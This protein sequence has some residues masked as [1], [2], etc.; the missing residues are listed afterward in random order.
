MKTQI[1]LQSVILLLF[2]S[3]SHVNGQTSSTVNSEMNT[4]IPLIHTSQRWTM[5]AI[6]NLRGPAER[7]QSWNSVYF[8]QLIKLSDVS[9]SINTQMGLVVEHK[10]IKYENGYNTLWEFKTSDKEAFLFTDKVTADSI[11]NGRPVI[12]LFYLFSGLKSVFYEYD[13]HGN[14]IRDIVSSVDTVTHET[15]KVYMYDRSY[16]DSL[17]T[18]FTSR[19]WDT[20]SNNWKTVFD[21]QESIEYNTNNQPVVSISYYNQDSV[22]G[23]PTGGNKSTY[24]YSDNFCL[25]RN[26]YYR[27]DTLSNWTLSSSDTFVNDENCYRISFTSNLGDSLVKNDYVNS[28]SSGNVLECSKSVFDTLTSSFIEIE[29]TNCEYNQYGDPI[30]IISRSPEGE[31][32]KTTQIIW[33]YNSISSKIKTSSF[34]SIYRLKVKNSSLYIERSLTASANDKIEIYTTSGRLISSHKLKY[35]QIRIPL[36]D[37]AKGVY[38]YRISGSEIDLGRFVIE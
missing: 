5:D 37:F 38:F 27:Y 36:V 20:N 35:Q 21:I 25:E 16:S 8:P 10:N 1:L 24:F 30:S 9:V 3:L 28:L 2:T 12:I 11:K 13:S 6:D 34:S 23:N 4:Q 31:V 26:D 19:E 33:D 17:Y 7:S 22:T 14:M 18:G 29:I 15:Q 32:L